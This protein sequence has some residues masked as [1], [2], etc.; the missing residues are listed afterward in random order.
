MNIHS[1]NKIGNSPNFSFF[2]L[3]FPPSSSFKVELSW[4]HRLNN[5][6][7]KFLEEKKGM[8]KTANQDREHLLNENLKLRAMLGDGDLIAFNSKNQQTYLF[9]FLILL[10]GFFFFFVILV[11]RK[12]VNSPS[13]L[14]AYMKNRKTDFL[15]FPFFLFTFK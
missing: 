2:H 4:K 1:T 15:F 8:L 11:P 12:T 6:T 13:P 9:L 5:E 7:R 10:Q 14:L 3:F